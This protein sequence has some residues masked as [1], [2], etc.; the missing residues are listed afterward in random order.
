MYLSV[1]IWGKGFFK[2]SVVCG[3]FFHKLVPTIACPGATTWHYRMLGSLGEGSVKFTTVLCF[4]DSYFL[5]S[6][7]SYTNS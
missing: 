1:C 7:L 3:F 2:F 4:G 6:N 5:I